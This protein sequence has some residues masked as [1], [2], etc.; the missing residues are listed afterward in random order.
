MSDYELA[1]MPKT[2]IIQQ[3]FDSDEKIFEEKINTLELKI[4]GHAASIDIL[5]QN[6]EA[7]HKSLDRIE[8][9]LDSIFG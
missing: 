7:L 1:G 5:Q 9:A 4:L 8:K 6:L 2:V 3:P